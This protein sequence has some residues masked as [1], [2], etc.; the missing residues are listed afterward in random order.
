MKSFMKWYGQPMEDFKVKVP[1]ALPRYVEDDEVEKL[2]GAID[3]KKTHRG[4]ITRDRMLV[5]LDIKTGMR[6]AELSN[7]EARDVH[8]DFLV[9]R[10]GK[11]VA[12]TVLYPHRHRLLAG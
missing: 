3:G 1:R 9:V 4:S 6:R 7:L 11:G 10:D 2:L 8:T 12:R 5:E